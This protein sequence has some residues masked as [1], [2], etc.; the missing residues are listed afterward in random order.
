MASHHETQLPTRIAITR[1]E[2]S[3]A[4]LSEAV[5][6]VLGSCA[7]EHLIWTEHKARVDR[8]HGHNWDAVK[9]FGRSEKRMDKLL[10]K[11][12]GLNVQ[13]GLVTVEASDD[14]Q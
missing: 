13:L 14:I 4:E 6:N 7:T 11:L 9:D 2:M 8:S 12:F 5:V 1:S 10:D 3:E